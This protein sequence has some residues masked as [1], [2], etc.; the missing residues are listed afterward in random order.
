MECHGVIGNLGSFRNSRRRTERK[1]NVCSRT[2]AVL[3][4][5]DKQ[6]M[7]VILTAYSLCTYF[8]AK[9]IAI[10]CSS[11]GQCLMPFS[12]IHRSLNHILAIT[13]TI[14]E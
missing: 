13:V 4:H 10:L 11:E 7:E 3:S 12:F 1:V 8:D 14:P 2:S 9:E 5:F 6:G